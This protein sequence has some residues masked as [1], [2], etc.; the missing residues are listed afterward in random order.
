MEQENKH[1][2]RT[3]GKGVKPALVHVN[4]RLPTWVVEF[5]RNKSNYTVAMREVLINYATSNQDKKD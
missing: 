2:R 4:V 1:I 3:R 5:Y